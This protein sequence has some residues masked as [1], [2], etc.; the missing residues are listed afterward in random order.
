MTVRENVRSRRVGRSIVLAIL[1][2]AGIAGVWLFGEH[3][4]ANLG[5]ATLAIGGAGLVAWWSTR[6][7]VAAFGVL[8][9]IASLSGWTIQLP[10]GNMRLEQPAIAAGLLAMLYA[11]RLPEPEAL[12]RLLP[13]AVAF[14]VYMGALTASSLLYSPDRA[15][16][17]RMVVWTGLSMAG[18]LL[19]FLLLFGGD[20]EGGPQWMC[21]AAAGQA[22]VG[23]AVAIAFSLLGPVILAGPDPMPGF[24]GKVLALSWEPN[25]YASLLAAL[26]LFAIEKLQIW[27]RPASAAVVALILLGLAFGLTRGAYL[28]LA[29]GLIVYA[30]VVLYRRGQP[31]SLLI[32]ASV[33]IGALVIGVRSRRSCCAPIA[34]GIS[35]S[36]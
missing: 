22:A 31:R 5:R 30:G 33:V 36:T 10:I 34:T 24:N 13:I 4:L 9:L 29:A 26:S 11:R 23:V 3:S 20:R 16:S 1:V 18:G 27:T 14:A 7:P 8:F 32:P 12:R 19:V 6:R 21:T 35:Q 2:V 28:G 17:L 25:I 15:D